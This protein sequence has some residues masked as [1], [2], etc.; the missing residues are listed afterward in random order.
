MVGYQHVLEY[1]RNIR[2]I[3]DFAKE[4]IKNITK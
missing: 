2:L 1:L 4:I 3:F